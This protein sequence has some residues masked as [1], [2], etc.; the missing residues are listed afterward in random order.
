LHGQ[1]RAAIARSAR[2]ACERTTGYAKNAACLRIETSAKPAGICFAGWL[3]R[4]PIGALQPASAALSEK[5]NCSCLS[6]CPDPDRHRIGG[7]RRP[8]QTT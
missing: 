2:R 3:A 6:K 7:T 1:L 4:R 5:E 8:T